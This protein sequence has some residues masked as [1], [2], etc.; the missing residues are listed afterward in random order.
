LVAVPS[1]ACSRSARPLT[2]L[3][4][5]AAHL[6]IFFALLRIREHLIGLVD[7][8]ESVFSRFVVRIDIWMILARQFAICLSNLFLT[9]ILIDPK[10]FVIVFI[11]ASHRHIPPTPAVSFTFSLKSH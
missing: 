7:L 10:D 3:L 9:C 5:V 6:I 8:L 11:F 4:V 1:C 2:I